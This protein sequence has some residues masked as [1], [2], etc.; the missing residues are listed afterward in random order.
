MKNIFLQIK[1]LQE[2]YKS[3][4]RSYQK[5]Q[6]PVIKQWINDQ[7]ESGTFIRTTVYA[8]LK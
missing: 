2:Q 5:F 3:F 7:I 1:E 4:I 8:P 6:N